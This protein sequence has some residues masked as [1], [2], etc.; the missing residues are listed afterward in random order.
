[1]VE[2][3]EMDW[4]R[5]HLTMDSSLKEPF[6]N[7]LSPTS[8]GISHGRLTIHSAPKA[9][10]SHTDWSISEVFGFPFRGE[11]KVQPLIAGSYRLDLPWQGKIGSASHLATALAGW[12]FLRFE[13]T[14]SARLGSDGEFYR[15]TPNLKM[16]FSTINETGDIVV[17]ENH[18]LSTISHNQEPALLEEKLFSLLGLPWDRELEPFRVAMSEEDFHPQNKISI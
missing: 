7:V 5:S 15:F 6:M 17:H 8:T 9:L 12:E 1:M 14:Q 2:N 11:W 13:I 16:H 10:C 3:R 4:G 18:I